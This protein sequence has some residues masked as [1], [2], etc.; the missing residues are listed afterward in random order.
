MARPQEYQ[1]E[2]A[3]I[4]TSKG[5][6]VDIRASIQELNIYESIE[7]PFLT[8][9]VFLVDTA[10]FVNQMEF[11]GTERLVIRVFSNPTKKSTR[12]ITFMMTQI[13]KSE[14]V[15]DYTEAYMFQL[16]E[17]HAFISRAMKISQS[18]K[19]SPLTMI[20]NL[21]HLINP[22]LDLNI[23]YMGNSPVQKDM[24]LIT[25]YITPLQAVEWIRDR[26]TTPKGLPFFLYSTIKEQGVYV[27]SLSQILSRGT[28]NSQPYTYSQ[29]TTNAEL[30]SKENVYE[31]QSYEQENV[32]NTLQAMVNGAVAAKWEVLDFFKQRFNSPKASEY[33]IDKLIPNNAIYD[34][35][36]VLSDKKLNEYQPKIFYHLV[37]SDLFS[38]GYVSYHDDNSLDSLV[39]KINNKGL[40]N[41]L[42]KNKITIDIGGIGFMASDVATVGT[43]MNVNFLSK[44]TQG[45]VDE[46]KSGDYIIMA[47][48]HTFTETTHR[49]TAEITKLSNT[50]KYNYTDLVE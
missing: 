35:S 18:F 5:Q 33:V 47:T 10:N 4:L 14:K 38:D 37:A 36:V 39:T 13:E 48:R 41:A 30:S 31:I 8:G 2:Q 9:T 43:M 34:T 3:D 7:K 17:E 46:R 44:E 27:N 29:A 28:W 16:L 25:P 11:T 19:G 42:L 26:C 50:E 1:L 15:N 45:G 49:V 24:R 32:D 6:T 12:T 21:L 20:S 40:R 22:S 23:T